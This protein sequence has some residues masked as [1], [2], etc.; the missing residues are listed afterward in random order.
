[1]TDSKPVLDRLRV[2]A[3]LH[4]A[5]VAMMPA[6]QIASS[7]IARAADTFSWPSGQSHINTP[8]VVSFISS[9]SATSLE[10]SSPHLQRGVLRFI[11]TA[12]SRTAVWS[13]NTMPLLD[14]PIELL[15]PIIH[16]VVR[17][18]GAERAWDLRAV[19]SMCVFPP[20]TIH[21]SD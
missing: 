19:C 7:T 21:S 11:K 9:T 4:D 2:Y 14:L 10:Y 16:E 6:N 12:L 20:I 8:E 3:N 1:M 5:T 13:Q 15:E 18:L 17:S